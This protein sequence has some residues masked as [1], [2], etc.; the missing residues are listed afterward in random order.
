MLIQE[1]TVKFKL[2]NNI[3]IQHALLAQSCINSNYFYFFSFLGLTFGE[4][5]I[6]NTSASSTLDKFLPDD[7]GGGG[8]NMGSANLTSSPLLNVLVNGT[9]S[10]LSNSSSFG[11][12]SNDGNFT[13]LANYTTPTADVVCVNRTLVPNPTDIGDIPA[14][15]VII[16][17]L[18]LSLWFYSI[19][20]TWSNWNKILKE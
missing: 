8:E 6:V 17:L 5:A 15:E 9:V 7:R 18:M 10:L 20:L 3:A 1:E 11:E 12:L 19:I 14:K 16:V 13:E 4:V 2:E